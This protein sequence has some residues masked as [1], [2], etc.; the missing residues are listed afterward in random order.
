MAINMS[1]WRVPLST[2]KETSG[3]FLYILLVINP[4]VRDRPESRFV[5][6]LLSAGAVGIE[7][8]GYDGGVISA[9][10]VGTCIMRG[11][12][13]IQ[14]WLADEGEEEK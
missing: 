4:F 5:K 10:G 8:A 11:I 6:G 3:I 7:V 2:W 13:K 12:L 14:S 9:E 1:L